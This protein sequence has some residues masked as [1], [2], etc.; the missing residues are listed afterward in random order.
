MPA[1]AVV[2]IPAAPAVLR[3]VLPSPQVP[4]PRV[5]A[6]LRAR[7]AARARG[8]RGAAAA[9][10]IVRRQ[11]PVAAI[12]AAEVDAAGVDL[13]AVL[14]RRAGKGGI[15]RAAATAHAPRRKRDDRA[16]LVDRGQAATAARG[17]ARD[18]C[19]AERPD[20]DV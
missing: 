4:V 2:T 9:A 11:V 5:P 10:A 15:G 17:A 18:A 19:G 6:V 13:G 3:V 12:A 16:A 14:G 8:A 7:G 1:A 20:R